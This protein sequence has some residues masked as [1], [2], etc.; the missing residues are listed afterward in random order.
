MRELPENY[1]GVAWNWFKTKYGLVLEDK[2]KIRGDVQIIELLIG[3]SKFKIISPVTF[4]PNYDLSI[5][6]G[7]KVNAQFVGNEPMELSKNKDNIIFKLKNH[8]KYIC[9]VIDKK[10][11]ILG[12]DPFAF[13]YLTISGILEREL[14]NDVFLK[15]VKEPFLDSLS[16][17]IFRAIRHLIINSGY[18]LVTKPFWPNN[19]QFAL[20]LTHDV[21]EVRKTY[22]YFTRSLKFLRQFD[23]KGIINEFHS[24]INKLRKNDDPYWTFNDLINIEK[25]LNVR[26][27][28]YFLREH[29]RVNLFNRK[30]WRHIGRRYTFKHPEIVKL[31]RELNSNGWEVGLHGSFYSYTNFNMLKEEK[32]ELEKA[33]GSKV[34]GVRQH[35]LNLSIPETWRIHEALSFDYDTTL[36]SNK[37]VGFRWGTCFPFYPYDT[38]MNRFLKVLQIPLHIEDIVI[39]RYQN[40]WENCRLLI[41]KVKGYKGV[42]TILWHHTVFNEVEYPNYAKLYIDIIKLSKEKDAWVTNAAEISKWWRSR[43]R[44]SPKIKY[45]KNIIQIITE[46]SIT[47]LKMKCESKNFTYSSEKTEIVKLN[48]S[49]LLIHFRDCNDDPSQ[50]QQWG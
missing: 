2:I 42:L 27:S 17:I 34:I 30:T 19:K 26:S 14:S 31:I 50:S 25:E 20:C 43:E 23:F 32:K 5:L 45:K 10:D 40:P 24:L 46:Y 49:E 28:F 12:F 38:V 15:L 8:K 13:I 44:F 22:Q 36:G 37:Y 6:Q 47:P 11:L 21:D 3:Q 7:L 1:L 33:L 29:G 48:T 39:F 9:G 18:P 16:E 4:N 41:D 35:N